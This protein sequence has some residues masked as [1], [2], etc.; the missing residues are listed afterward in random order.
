MTDEEIIVRPPWRSLTV[1]LPCNPGTGYSWDLKDGN[2]E[3]KS[4]SVK[5]TNRLGGGSAETFS[6]EIPGRYP[7]VTGPHVLVFQYKRS[8]EDGVA[9]EHRVKVSFQP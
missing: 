9:R 6:L 1:T 2:V 3:I 4:R 7:N 5:A 8:W